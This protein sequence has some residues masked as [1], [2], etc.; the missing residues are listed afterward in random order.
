MSKVFVHPQTGAVVWKEG[1]GSVTKAN[2]HLLEPKP[3]APKT[4]KLEK[5]E[6]KE[7]VIVDEKT[8]PETVVEKP[9]RKAPAKPRAKKVDVPEA[10]DT[11]KAD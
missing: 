8:Q 10:T 7:P 11:T 6:V 1:I 5:I 2:R 9:K 3:R 4:P